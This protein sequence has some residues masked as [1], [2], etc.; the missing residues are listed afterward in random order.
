MVVGRAEKTAL[1]MT[2]SPSTII[3]AFEPRDAADFQRLN[4]AWIGSLFA[5]EAHDLE[6][7]GDPQGQ[8]IDPGGH[9]LMAEQDGR[10]VGCCALIPLPEGGFELAKMTVD[11][12]LR[13]SGLGRALMARAVELA[14]SLGAPRVYLE[15]NSSLASAIGL[16]RAFGFVDLPP[17]RRP[18]KVYER[19]DVW[20]ELWLTHQG[21]V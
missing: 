5:L 1:G 13:G 20:M 6:V 3:R 12:T 4:E 11:E 15:T 21:G 19:G 7:L 18:P 2:T 8:I 17:E 14:R 10:A 16:Y 9:I